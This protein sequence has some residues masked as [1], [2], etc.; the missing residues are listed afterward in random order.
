[1][2]QPSPRA[3]AL[4]AMREQKYGREQARQAAERKVERAAAKALKSDEQFK[5]VKHHSK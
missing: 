5:T 1:M 3:D 2:K 4:Q